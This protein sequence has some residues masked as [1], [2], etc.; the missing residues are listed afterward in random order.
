MLILMRR[1]EE[2]IVIDGNIELKILKI[3]GNQVHLGLNAPKDIKIFR[4][5]IFDKIEKEN[6]V[7]SKPKTSK[8]I[9]DDIFEMVFYSTAEGFNGE[10]GDLGKYFKV[11]EKLYKEFMEGRNK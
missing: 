1:L 9:F 7:P 4:K 5:E 2:S 3:Q 6:P 8:E 11:K 10:Y